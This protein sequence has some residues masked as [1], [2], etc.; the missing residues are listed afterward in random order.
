MSHVISENHVEIG[1]NNLART[2]ELLGLPRLNGVLVAILTQANDLEAVL[3]DLFTITSIE[4]SEGAQLD[5]IG[6][7]LGTPRTGLDDFRYRSVLR[8]TIA[9]NRSFGTPPDIYL[10]AH[11][12]VGDGATGFEITEHYP[13]KFALI[14]KD[15]SLDFLSANI[16][17]RL[18]RKAKSI[19]VGMRLWF[20][21]DVD[22]AF[23][24]SS[25]LGVI[26]SDPLLGFGWTGDLL[27]GGGYGWSLDGTL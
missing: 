16:L 12:F 15:V 13:A 3:Q 2:G 25:Q 27:L 9:V 17:A 20:A 4:N 21:D 7:V 26:E 24:F 23:T 11:L 10:V 8:A 22:N 14:A 6:I 1:L 19:A 5:V 18:L